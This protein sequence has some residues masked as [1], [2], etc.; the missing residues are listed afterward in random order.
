MKVRDSEFKDVKIIEDSYAYDI[1]GNFIKTFNEEEFAEHG[2]S[3]D[4]R[5]I[6]YST[7]QRDVIRGMHFQ[8]PPYE[9]D[10]LIHVIRGHVIDVVLD[11]RKSSPN[12]KKCLAISLSG[13]KPYSIYIPKGFAHGFKCLENNTVMLYH[14]TSGYNAESDT[15]IA[16]DSIGYDWNVEDPIMSERDQGFVRLEDFESPFE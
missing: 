1:R 4:L 11:L 12:Y 15:G 7:S 8:L 16:Y 9:H 13:N 10:K 5:E 3:T 2:L 14:V 6:Y